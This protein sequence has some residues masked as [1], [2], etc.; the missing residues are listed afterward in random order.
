MNI[1]GNA[2]FDAAH[3]VF[4]NWANAQAAY[5]FGVLTGRST[6]VPAPHPVSMIDLAELVYAKPGPLA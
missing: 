2:S 5:A 4:Q 6:E 1:R 3:K